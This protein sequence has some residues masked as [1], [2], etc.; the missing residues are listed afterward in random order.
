[1]RVVYLLPH[2]GMCGGVKVIAEHVT[3]LCAR[4]IDAAVW[5]LTGGFGWFPRPVPYFVFP[6][7]DALGAA[8]QTETDARFVATFWI[9]ASWVPPNLRG[10]SRGFYLIQDHDELTYGGSSAGT[11]YRQGLTHITEGKFVTNEITR[12]YG[13]PCRNVG[14]GVDSNVFAPLPMIRERFR[15]LTPFR[16][17]SAGPAG[18]KG[19]DVAETALRKLAAAEPRASVVT[20]GIEGGPVVD[21]MPHI[22]LH[23][24]SDAKLREL[25]AQSGVFL[26]ASRHEGFGLPMLEAMACACPVVCT[27]AN[28]NREF[29]R[30]GATA[31]VS[32]SGDA[33]GLAGNLARVM[34]DPGAASR[35]GAAGL[36]ESTRYR[37]TE[38]IDRLVAVL[39]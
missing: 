32:P 28:G 10:A 14:I 37:W 12:L 35:I 36:A 13:T 11:S 19:W 6:S 20:F 15:V 22:H 18:L 25:Y 23:Y 16:T 30:D 27:D 39:G 9:T 21:W 24:P 5:G 8:M 4:G 33:D 17:H 38:V 3:G 29:C 1:M 7:T 26:S 2:A 31:L 34:G